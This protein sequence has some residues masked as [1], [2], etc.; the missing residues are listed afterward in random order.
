MCSFKINLNP[1]YKTYLDSFRLKNRNG[2]LWSP[3]SRLWSGCVSSDPRRE[4]LE[5]KS[6]HIPLDEIQG[7]MYRTRLVLSENIRF[8]FSKS[9]LISKCLFSIFNSPNKRTIKINFTTM[10]PQVDLFSFTF[11]EN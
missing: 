5:P 8:R 1:F 6:S 2:P 9:Q 3:R 4:L 10:V 11:W 7:F